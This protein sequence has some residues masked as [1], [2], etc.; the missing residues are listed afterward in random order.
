[1]LRR[2]Q[3][4]GGAAVVEGEGGRLAALVRHQRVPQGHVL[5]VGRRAR[6]AEQR[7]RAALEHEVARLLAVARHVLEQGEERRAQV[8]KERGK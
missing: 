8:R 3:D 7:R 4:G 1:M 5:A 6:G 2:V